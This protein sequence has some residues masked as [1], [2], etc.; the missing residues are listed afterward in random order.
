MR[1]LQETFSLV[2]LNQANSKGNVPAQV[3]LLGTSE[4]EL[5]AALLPSQSLLAQETAKRS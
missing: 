3:W 2:R 5:T 4:S 1:E